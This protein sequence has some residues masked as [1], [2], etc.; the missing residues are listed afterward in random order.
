[1]TLPLAPASSGRV[2]AV[3]DTDTFNEVDDQFALAH[4]LLSP[5]RVQLEAVYA[6]PFHNSRSSGPEQGMERSYEEI[7]RVLAAMEGKTP[8]TTEGTRVPVYRGSRQWLPDAKTPV[9]SEAAR[10]LVEL[11]MAPAPAAPR[12]VAGEDPAQPAVWASDKLYVV[13]IG[14]PTNVASALLMEPRIAERIV[15]VWLGGNAPYWRTAKEFNLQ[16]DL[17]ASRIIVDVTAPLVLVPCLPIA[18]NVHTTVA[19]LETH[20]APYS[21]LGEYLTNIVRSYDKNKPGWS[22]V[23]WDIAATAWII[24]HT[25]SFGDALPSPALLDDMTWRNDPGRPTATIINWVKRD[26]VFADFFAKCKALG[27]E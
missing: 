25:W 1:M 14:A 6:A 19:E 23:I 4:L 15:V 22:K 10:H 18:S 12:P 17:H 9:E 24:D 13:A 7:M 2:R 27:K 11:A 8:G 5:L 21:A 26:P 16:Q 20:L 3:L